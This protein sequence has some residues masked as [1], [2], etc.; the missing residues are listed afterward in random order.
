MLKG[1]GLRV[2]DVGFV[3]IEVLGV[4][5]DVALGLSQLYPDNNL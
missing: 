5:F 3:R 2:R 4:V 1:L